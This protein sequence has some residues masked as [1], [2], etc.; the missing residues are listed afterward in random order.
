VTRP[1]ART[2]V[3]LAEDHPLVL[4]AVVRV[5][6]E[7]PELEVVGTAVNG[8]EALEGLRELSPDVALVDVNMPELTGLDLLHAVK[9][10]QLDVRVV[11]LTGSIDSEGLHRALTLGAKGVLSKTTRGRQICEAVEA[12]A[13]GEVRISEEFQA[14]L[15]EELQKRSDDVRPVLTEREG[16]VL[17]LTAEGC[18]AAEI[19]ERLGLAV[20]T[21]RTHL[22]KVYEKLGVST[23][24]AAVAEGMRRRML[25]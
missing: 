16:E 10:D 21:V 6:R 20:P 4:D 3:Y 13:R 7:R 18:S 2:R 12:V 23:A 11:L 15:S 19:G 9:R 17:R 14:G 22:A 25:E 24:P 5:I 1:K 8:P